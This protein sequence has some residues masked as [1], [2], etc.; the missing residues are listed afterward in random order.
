M[1]IKLNISINRIWGRTSKSNCMVP[2]HSQVPVSGARSFRKTTCE[3]DRID[4][5]TILHLT[6][7]SLP[8]DAR[9]SRIGRELIWENGNMGVRGRNLASRGMSLEYSRPQNGTL[10]RTFDCGFESG[11]SIIQPEWQ[12]VDYYW[13]FQCTWSGYRED[14]DL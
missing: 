3:V 13:P 12:L 8:Q 11:L 6:T 10:A 7:S 5:F 2:G 4:G 9:D 1:K 14:D